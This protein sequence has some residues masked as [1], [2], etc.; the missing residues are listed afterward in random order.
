MSEVRAEYTAR[1]FNHDPSVVA[2]AAHKFGTVLVTNRGK[3]ALYVVEAD[4]YEARTRRHSLLS[5]FEDAGVDEDVVGEPAK[6]PIGLR[7]V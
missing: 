4:E 5:V 6:L 7:Q 3:P 1:E 2:R